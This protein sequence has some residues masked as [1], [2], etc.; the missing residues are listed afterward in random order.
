MFHL[1]ENL[2]SLSTPERLQVMA[3]RKEYLKIFRQVCFVI[4]GGIDLLLNCLFQTISNRVRYL[5]S[6]KSNTIEDT[7]L[8]AVIKTL[9]DVGG[10][11]PVRMPVE[12]VWYRFN[13]DQLKSAAKEHTL[14]FPQRDRIRAF[15]KYISDSFDRESEV[16]KQKMK[17]ERDAI[18]EEELKAWRERKNWDGSV[19][20]LNK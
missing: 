7:S 10:T 2:S 4:L 13:E 14:H 20:A 6:I 1:N 3:A 18:Y 15:T 16:V 12:R 5:E 8:Q 11:A 9:L 17:E 19:T